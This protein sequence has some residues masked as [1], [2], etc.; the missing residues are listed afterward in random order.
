[1]VSFNDL[2]HNF[3]IGNGKNGG[4]WRI[5]EFDFNKFE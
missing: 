2:G 3:G 1:M 5:Y 4:T